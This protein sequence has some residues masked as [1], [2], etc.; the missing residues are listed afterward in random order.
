MSTINPYSA[1][2]PAQ[3]SIQAQ[4]ARE[5]AVASAVAALYTNSFANGDGQMVHLGSRYDG[6][7]LRN[8]RQPVAD[9]I[10][11]LL[12]VTPPLSPEEIQARANGMVAQFRAQHPAPPTVRAPAPQPTAPA[13]GLSHAERM[14]R[15]SAHNVTSGQLQYNVFTGPDGKPLNLL[16]SGFS[17]A[18]INERRAP[19]QAQMQ[20]LLTQQP[21]LSAAEIR[22]QG[23]RI[24][25]NFRA[26]FSGGPTAT[27]ATT[28]TTAAGATDEAARRAAMEQVLGELRGMDVLN[29][30][31]TEFD[32]TDWLDERAPFEA[33]VR[34]LMD[35]QPPL[36]PDEIRTRGQEIKDGWTETGIALC[37]LI[38]MALMQSIT[39]MM[40]Q[41]QI[42]DMNSMY[43]T[44]GAG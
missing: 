42:H 38:E 22:T 1:T 26:T 24:I 18:Q 35:V 19:F 32:C 43:G 5:G 39:M 3:S 6:A 17:L 11:A 4:R 23:D 25:N 21:P 36:T 40:N 27:T 9:E 8:D 13:D 28:A 7:T 34:A 20:A 44:Y 14:Q 2:T 10:R 16:R 30:E 12:N 37:L 29:Y 41:P 31:G 33:E 15:I